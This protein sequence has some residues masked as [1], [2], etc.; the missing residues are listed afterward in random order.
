M[1]AALENG[2]IWCAL[3]SG[4]NGARRGD[5]RLKSR[6]DLL[7][8]WLLVETG[9]DIIRPSSLALNN[10]LTCR[11]GLSC[12]PRSSLIWIRARTESGSRTRWAPCRQRSIRRSKTTGTRFVFARGPCVS[13]SCSGCWPACD[14]RERV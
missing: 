13:L 11:L 2:L 1:T 8:R 9:R 10:T 12:R 4:S 5:T 6:R 7:V 14:N 3:K